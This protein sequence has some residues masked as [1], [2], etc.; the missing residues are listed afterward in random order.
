MCTIALISLFVSEFYGKT[1]LCKRKH[2]KFYN[3]SPYIAEF[4]NTLT[5]L[6]FILIGLYNILYYQL[7][8]NLM[9]AY[10]LLIGC[11]IGSSIHHAS[12]EEWTIVID[13][14]PILSSIIFALWSGI[15]YSMSAITLVLTIFAFTILF[16]DH[17]F[18]PMPVPWGHCLWHILASI[19][20]N[21]LYSDYYYSL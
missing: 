10:L 4:W 11:G 7:D 13:W 6:P 18:T 5:N 20:V 8:F 16:T 2:E 14:I 19:A 1:G 12:H 9:V 3:V 21:S 15:V 17:A